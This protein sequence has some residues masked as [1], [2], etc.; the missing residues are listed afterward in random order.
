MYRQDH[1]G[2]Y[3]LTMVQKVHHGTDRLMIVQMGSCWTDELIL[4]Q[5][6]SFWNRQARNGTDGL[7]T[8]QT[9]SQPYRRP[10][11][12]RDR[13]TTVLTLMTV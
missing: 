9:D 12:C 13:L 8:K 10:H 7:I 5:I 6:G 11:N 3:G 1:D 2:I 4:V